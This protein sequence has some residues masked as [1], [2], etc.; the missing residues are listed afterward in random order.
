MIQYR[1]CLVDLL[2]A[3]TLDLKF[4]YLTNEA[5]SASDHSSFW[6]EGVG[7]IEVLENF[8][9]HNFENGCGETDRNPNYHTEGDRVSA[10]N[11]ATAHA[12]ARAAILTA[13]T[14]AEPAGN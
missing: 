4:D 6:R 11:L 2:D 13:A 5:I 12:I 3:Y 7:A 14:L 1:G 10:L 8:S 9:T